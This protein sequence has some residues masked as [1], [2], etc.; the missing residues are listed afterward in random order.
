[1]CSTALDTPDHGSV[2]VSVDTATYSCFTNYK[3]EGTAT[4]RCSNGEWLG[5][6]P[7][8]VLGIDIWHCMHDV[9]C[10]CNLL[11]C[12]SL[13]NPANGRVTVSG[14]T[15][16]YEC[17][18][19]YRLKGVTVRTCVNKQWTGTTSICSKGI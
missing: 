19:G 16:Q 1:M 3:I 11:E 6:T 7:T 8:C 5:D 13:D 12:R 18:S 9:M 2:R 10:N 14:N 15:A 17:N 4:R